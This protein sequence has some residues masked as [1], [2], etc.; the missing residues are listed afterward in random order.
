MELVLH[1]I[2]TAMDWIGKNIGIMVTGSG[3]HTVIA[4]ANIKVVAAITV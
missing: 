3:V 2:V 1:P 4:M